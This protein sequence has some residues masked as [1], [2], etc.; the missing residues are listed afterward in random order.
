MKCIPDSSGSGESALSPVTHCPFC[1]VQCA[2]RRSASGH[3][4]RP[5]QTHTVARGKTCRKGQM[6][7]GAVAVERRIRRAL[8][9]TSDGLVPVSTERALRHAA[10]S[11]AQLQ[12]LYGRETVGV[13]G[14]GALLNEEAYLLGKFARVA[15]RTPYI[16]YNGRYCMASAAYAMNAAFGLD[17]GLPFPAEDIADAEFVL[18]LGANLA[19]CQ[20]TLVQYL[21]QMRKRGG[22]LTVVDPRRTRTADLA[23]EHLAIAPGAD[24][25]LLKGLLKVVVEEG[26][27]DR[28]YIRARTSGF[29]SVE[30]EARGLDLEW[31]ARVT[32]IPAQRIRELG[33]RFALTPRAMLL[34]ARGVEQQE[35]GVAAVLACI[36]FALATGKVGRRAGGYGSITGQA[37][38][39]GG[40]ELGQKCDQLPG[41]RSLADE[42][43]REFVS[44]VWGVDASDLPGCGVPAFEIFEKIHAG[45]IRALLVVGANPAVSSPDREY[46]RAAFR[47][48]DLLVVV[49]LM[50]TETVQLADVVIPGCAFH[51]KSGTVT[52][53][54]GRVLLKSAVFTPPTGVLPEWRIIREFAARLGHADQFDYNSEQDVFDELRRATRGARADYSGITYERLLREP[55]LHWPCAE[56]WSPGTPRLFTRAFAHADGRA[57]FVS[58]DDLTP[59][60]VAAGLLQPGDAGMVDKREL[61]LITGRIAHHYNTGSWTRE[62]AALTARAPRP[63]VEMHP[64]TATALGLADG[65]CVNV[66]NATGEKQFVLRLADRIRRDTLFIPFHW[67]GSG[68]VNDL[69]P[70]VLDPHSRIP[71]FK[72]TAVTVTRA[73]SERQSPENDR[74]GAVLAARSPIIAG[75]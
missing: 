29:A 21:V 52:N 39:Q 48:L 67:E 30:A 11:V 71:A 13:Y 54:E 43:D 28:H 49:E 35:Y 44:A 37:N 66:R 10:R 17:R 19:E 4:L 12:A 22:R 70:A 72:R 73:R 59:S 18:L 6:S 62:V 9:R 53:L 56:E 26:L 33:R 36:N 32:D 14:S 38:G 1:S 45:E 34:T 60:A 31:I 61:T 15:L 41:Y 63:W 5:V 68:A 75:E 42:D 24:V 47:K 3:T 16:D 46:V 69:V 65:E 8:L 50:P 25:W 58:S 27:L 51:E 40:R 23:D 74:E 64:E 7:A 20:P 57:R 2:L 55:A